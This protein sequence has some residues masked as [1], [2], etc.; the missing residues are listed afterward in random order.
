MVAG[1]ARRRAWPTRRRPW[2]TGHRP[3]FEPTTRPSRPCRINPLANGATPRCPTA[4]RLSSAW[5]QS[6]R[7]KVTRPEPNTRG[8][9]VVADTLDAAAEAVN[10]VAPELQPGA[11]LRGRRA[12]WASPQCSEYANF[13]KRL[14]PGVEVWETRFEADADAQTRRETSLVILTSNNAPACCHTPVGACWPTCAG[15]S[16]WSSQAEA[17]GPTRAWSR[18]WPPPGRWS[19]ERSEAFG[20]AACEGANW[21]PGRAS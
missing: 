1:P 19:G 21:W 3:G 9:I 17:P 6:V 13:A 8:V 5:R 12:S 4:S 20:P 2:V 11:S 18:G 15:T 10:V 7:L 14:E 16:T